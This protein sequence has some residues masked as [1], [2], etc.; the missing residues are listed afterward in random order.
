MSSQ[1]AGQASDGFLTPAE[2]SAGLGYV[3]GVEERASVAVGV[4]PEAIEAG[5]RIFADWLLENS[6]LIREMGGSGDTH[7]LFAALW[8]TWKNER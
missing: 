5:E 4:P 6:D 8:A 2:F 3:G 7:T 1:R